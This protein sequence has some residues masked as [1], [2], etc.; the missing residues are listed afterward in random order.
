MFEKLFKLQENKTTVTREIMAGFVTFMTMA[1]I[2]FVNPGILSNAMGKDL[3]PA[4]TVATCLA[5]GIMTICMGVFSN[6]PLALASGMGLNAVVTFGLV[7]QMKLSWQVAM[8]MVFIEGIVITILV[9]TNFRIWVMNAIPTDLKRAIGVGI[10]LFIA[11]IGLKDAG[12]VV[13]DPATLVKLGK[14]GP[15]QLIAVFGLLLT[16]ILMVRKVKGA[17]LIGILASTIVGILVGVA[18]LPAESPWVLGIQPEYFKT[19]FALDI[20]GALK[21]SLIIPIFTLLISDFFDTM[22]TIV[23][24]GEEAGYLTQDGKVPHLKSALMVDSLAAAVGGA[25]GC[26]SVTTYIESASGVGEGGRTGLTSVVVGILFLLAMFI[27]PI[28]GIVPAAA[29]APALIVVGFL[30]LTVVKVMNWEDMTTAIPAFLTIVAIPLTFS[31][32][33]GIGIGFISYVIVKA[34]SGKHKDVHPLMYGVALAFGL[35]FAFL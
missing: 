10:G 17:I 26:S 28:V 5:A 8:G 14:I 31:I 30:M 21:L 27:A 20:M 4:I 22:G 7:I 6:Y 18:K 29:T 11:F 2:I 32:T 15:G 16:I 12:L 24:V 34:L 3:I 25:F 23:A 33:N 13:T 19:F 1:Y 35:Y 9:L